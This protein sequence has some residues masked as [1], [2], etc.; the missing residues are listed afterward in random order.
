MPTRPAPSP[1]IPTLAGTPLVPGH[2]SGALL[3]TDTSLSFWGG[4]DP[5][6]GVVIDRHHPLHGACLAGT[7]LALP[8][9]R[10]SCTGSSVLL[11]LIL[12]GHAPAAV[13]VCEPEEILTLGA[14]VAE[15]VFR[16]FDAGA[17]AVT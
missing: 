2:A 1:P 6:S 17:A 3:H 15:L 8:S 5:F 4:V 7:V 16:P 14:L 12:N 11:E 9:S 10:G 13:I